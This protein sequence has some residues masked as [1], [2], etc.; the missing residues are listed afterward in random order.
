ML[1]EARSVRVAK[2]RAQ[3][4]GGEAEAGADAVAQAA[5]VALDL[6]GVD[7]PPR[8]G[9][10]HL[11]GRGGDPDADGEPLDERGVGGGGEGDRPGLAP[12][13]GEPEREAVRALDEGVL[14]ESDDLGAAEPP[15]AP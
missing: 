2:V 12:L 13:T 10:E 5:A 15:R 1:P 9:H 8:R 7:R 3:D 4:V 11:G 14:G 6:L